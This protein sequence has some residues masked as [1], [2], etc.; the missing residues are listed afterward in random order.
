MEKKLFRLPPPPKAL[1]V[2]ALRDLYLSKSRLEALRYSCRGRRSPAR[3]DVGGPRQRIG[4]A[5][6]VE[7]GAPPRR[8]TRSS[9]T[10]ARTLL[11]NPRDVEV[12]VFVRFAAVPS[13]CVYTQHRVLRRA[14]TVV[15]R[16]IPVD[17]HGPRA[18]HGVRGREGVK[19]D[20][21]RPSRRE[22][23]CSISGAADRT[24]QTT[25]DRTDGAGRVRRY[26]RTE[27]TTDSGRECGGGT[28][29]LMTPEPL[30]R[31]TGHVARRAR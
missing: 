1:F 5:Y 7:R 27:P 20:G 3:D 2:S 11:H 13:V 30:G 19:T 12:C 26:R 15:S 22:N 10:G 25:R 31:W 21:E 4:G 6:T 23:C 17:L 16:T 8:C 14:V 29:T 18:L 9:D 28:R 24:L